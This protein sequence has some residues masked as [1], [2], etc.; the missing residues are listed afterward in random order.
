MKRE[1]SIISIM[2]IPH[3]GDVLRANNS[4]GRN[5]RDLAAVSLQEM[6]GC[7]LAVFLLTIN[8]YGAVIAL[9]VC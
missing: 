9:E 3:D 8:G 5:G 7:G 4:N 1:H 2:H 6:A